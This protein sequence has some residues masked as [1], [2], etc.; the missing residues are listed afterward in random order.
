MKSRFWAVQKE[1]KIFKIELYRKSGS[2]IISLCKAEKQSECEALHM[3]WS[4]EAAFEV[5]RS[6]KFSLK[7]E[8]SVSFFQSS[9]HFE[10]ID[11]K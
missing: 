10:I 5:F 9:Y 7:S 6:V 8:F 4:A 11:K 3:F 1:N 2:V